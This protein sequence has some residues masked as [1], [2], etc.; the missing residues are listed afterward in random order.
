MRPDT[1]LDP[2][3]AMLALKQR[4][5]LIVDRYAKPDNVM[6][7]V[8]SLTTLVPLAGLW[9]LVAIGAQASYGLVVLAT[10]LMVLFLLRVFS[11]MHECG[12]GSLFRSP[13]LNSIF[14]FVFGVIAGMPQYVWSAHHKVHH[15]TNGNWARYRGPLAILSVDEYEALTSP[16]QR[17]YARA[18]NLGMAPLAGF[19]Y[20]VLNPR[21][22]WLKGTATLAW[23]L[24]TAK[25][26]EPTVPL[27]VHAA[28]FQTPYWKSAAEYRHMTLN[29]LVLF[30]AWALMSWLIGPALFFG[31]YV[32]ATSLAGA[33]G[34]VLFTV[35]HNFEHSYA[36]G[37]EN[38]DYDHAAIHGT[39]FLVLPAW[40]NWFT[41]NIGYHHIHHLSSRI[42]SHR[43][44]ACHVEY[45]TLFANVRRLKLADI[46]ASLKFVLWDTQ[47]RQLISVAEHARMVR[48]A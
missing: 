18:R 4:K 24:L 21:L 34:I 44:V 15:A 41:A 6:G 30:G 32:I 45:E 16:Q 43:L 28:R 38:W 20:V 48:A 26:L 2:A 5:R 40:L 12:H 25:W 23:H 29:N 37:E 9:V 14:G 11:L 42:P 7:C 33:A 19:L 17:A 13:T 36:S 46:A 3:A 47:S 22:T 27:K 10:A 31:V 8:L 35:Q 39:S 1:G